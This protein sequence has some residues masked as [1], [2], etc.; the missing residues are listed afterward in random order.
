M[1]HKLEEKAKPK[2]LLMDESSTY[3]N[4]LRQQSEQLAGSFTCH[5]MTEPSTL[6]RKKGRC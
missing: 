2:E 4:T 1:A 6:A 5:S 3:L